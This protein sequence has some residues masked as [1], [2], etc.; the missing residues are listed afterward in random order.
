MIEVKPSD[1]QPWDI[2]RNPKR[3]KIINKIMRHGLVSFKGRVLHREEILGRIS[4]QS[5]QPG[6]HRQD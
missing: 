4:G 6:R 3:E 1:G 5:A 2:S